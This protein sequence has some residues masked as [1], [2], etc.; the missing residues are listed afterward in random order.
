MDV[1]VNNNK[2][3]TTDHTKFSASITPIYNWHHRDR[4]INNFCL[5]SVGS[6]HFIA[7]DL[8]N[9]YR[10]FLCDFTII[11]KA[12]VGLN[13]CHMI[14][15]LLLHQQLIF[16]SWPVWKG[17]WIRNMNPRKHGNWD[18]FLLYMQVNLLHLWLRKVNQNF[19]IDLVSCPT[20]SFSLG[21][22]E[23]NCCT[24]NAKV[25]QPLNTNKTVKNCMVGITWIK[26][27]HFL[28]LIKWSNQEIIN[29]EI[30]PPVLLVRL[31]VEFYMSFSELITL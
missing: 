12:S 19:G 1:N 9:C 2:N 24:R 10:R 18:E 3:K 15:N 4:E 22:S 28:A 31:L 21:D 11:F 20:P 16:A 7:I 29:V 6:M 30:K 13:L 23:L 27:F 8:I 14:N 26:T 25:G 5:Y 17:D